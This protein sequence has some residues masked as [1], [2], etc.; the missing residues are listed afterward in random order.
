M[1][2]DWDLQ[3]AMGVGLQAERTSLAW[4]RTLIVLAAIFGIVSVHGYFADQPWQIVGLTTCLAGGTLATSAPVSH[5]R[6]E[7]I[8]REIRHHRTV[9][10]TLPALGLTLAT[11]AAS[12]LA[13]GAI[14]MHQY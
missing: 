6:L 9:T 3:R 2:E 8:T 10:A 7:S 5:K 11:T 13:L 14:V 12:A 4:S 1:T